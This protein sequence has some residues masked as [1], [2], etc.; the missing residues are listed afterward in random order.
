MRKDPNQTVTK[1]NES[2][3]KE[4]HLAIRE[5]EKKKINTLFPQNKEKP[6]DRI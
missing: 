2:G 6:E 5:E 4:A 3:E 1:Y